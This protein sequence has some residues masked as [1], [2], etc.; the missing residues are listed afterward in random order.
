MFE[1]NLAGGERLFLEKDDSCF[2]CGK[3]FMFSWNIFHGEATSHCCGAVYQLKDFH[4]DNPSEEQKEHSEI[5]AGDCIELKIDK[6]HR[7]I[8]KKLY[9]ELKPKSI[10]DDD[11]YNAV[12]KEANSCQVNQTN[13]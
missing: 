9:T 11:F 2:I 8:V 1:K 6:K 4:Y 5:L 3:S 10:N 13:G 7:D 12:M